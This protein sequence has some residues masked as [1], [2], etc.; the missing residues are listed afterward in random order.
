MLPVELITVLIHAAL[1]QHKAI[2]LKR[3]VTAF[4]IF[5]SNVKV[6]TF[7]NLRRV[8]AWAGV[9]EGWVKL[10]LQKRCT[11]MTWEMR[12]IEAPSQHFYVMSVTF[13]HH[14]NERRLLPLP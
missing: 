1:I 6:A 7:N 12:S 8:P 10:P 2:H 13:R 3:Q 14:A 4:Q 9:K 11:S 5:C